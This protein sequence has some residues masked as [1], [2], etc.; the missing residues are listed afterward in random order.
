[1][2]GAIG[3]FHLAYSSKPVAK[4]ELSEWIGFCTWSS[5]FS[6]LVAATYFLFVVYLG[7]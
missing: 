3:Y 6:L 4:P 5:C 7:D 2:L 1:L